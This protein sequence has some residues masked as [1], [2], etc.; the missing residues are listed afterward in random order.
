M[1]PESKKSP[2]QRIREAIESDP[3]TLK[4][5]WAFKSRFGE[6]PQG[7]GKITKRLIGQ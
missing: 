4:D 7:M 6:W 3:T 1:K 2:R 5:A